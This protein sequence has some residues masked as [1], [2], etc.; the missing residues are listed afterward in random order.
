M[1]IQT[2]E[3]MVKNPRAKGIIVGEKLMAASQKDNLEFVV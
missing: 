2:I 1:K 3:H